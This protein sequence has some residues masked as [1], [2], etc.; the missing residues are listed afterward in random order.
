MYFKTYQ[1]HKHQKYNSSSL[2]QITSA[3]RTMNRY[4]ILQVHPIWLSQVLYHDI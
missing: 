2:L 3:V 4:K 1:Y